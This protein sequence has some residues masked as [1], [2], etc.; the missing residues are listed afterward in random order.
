M[1]I[2]AIAGGVCAAKGFRA[3]GV[4]AAIKYQGR[5]DVALVVAAAPCAAA[6]EN[7]SVQNQ[8]AEGSPA[9]EPG[10]NSMPSWQSSRDWIATSP[11]VP[12]RSGTV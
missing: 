2:K 8:L 3:A 4:P 7:A 12:L 1:K 10:K 5:N 11:P 9:G 6:G